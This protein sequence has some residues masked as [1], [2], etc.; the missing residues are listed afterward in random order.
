MATLAEWNGNT[1][2]SAGVNSG[3]SDGIAAATSGSQGQEIITHAE[4]SSVYSTSILS[5]SYDSPPENVPEAFPNAPDVD[6]PWTSTPTISAHLTDAARGSPPPV[7]T[8]PVELATPGGTEDLQVSR[9]GNPSL[10]SHPNRTGGGNNPVDAPSDV[11]NQNSTLMSSGEPDEAPS[12]G[13]LLSLMTPFSLGNSSQTAISTRHSKSRPS[14]TPTSEPAVVSASS[15]S[16]DIHSLNGAPAL[17][18]MTN[19][20]ASTRTART[21]AGA[22]VAGVGIVLLIVAAVY[23][24]TRRGAMRSLSPHTRFPSFRTKRKRPTSTP[25]NESEEN[26]FRREITQ[27]RGFDLEQATVTSGSHYSD[28]DDDD[29]EGWEEI[30]IRDARSGNLEKDNGEWLEKWRRGKER[31]ISTRRPEESRFNPRLPLPPVSLE[32]QRTDK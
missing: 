1:T 19:D 13:I 29:E 7:S 5:N 2:S 22:T 14:H 10:N 27:I 31:M 20:E 3:Q 4:S 23:V 24:Y 9:S 18:T 30:D 17:P 32:G 6:I 28:Y 8:N 11:S 16:S 15:S 25:I 26:F 21:I 12:E